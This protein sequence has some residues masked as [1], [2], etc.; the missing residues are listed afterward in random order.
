MQASFP[1]YP[2][3]CDTLQNPIFW[4]D[5]NGTFEHTMACG[6]EPAGWNKCLPG[7]MNQPSD[8]KCACK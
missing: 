6:P 8:C 5:N 4:R 3:I 7:D 2:G 1:Q